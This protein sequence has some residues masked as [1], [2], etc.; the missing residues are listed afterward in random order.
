MALQPSVGPWPLFQFLNLYTVGRTPWTVDEPVARTTQTE[1][2][3]TQTPMPR[4]GFEPMV[5]VFVRAKTV[6]ATV[7]GRTLHASLVLSF[8]LSLYQRVSVLSL[9][10]SLNLHLRDVRCSKCS[11]IL[12]PRG[13]PATDPHTIATATWDRD[14][15][16]WLRDHLTWVM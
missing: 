10:L 12:I 3:R 15:S 13:L 9:L 4:V 5:Q 11:K 1:N 6:H 8:S 14:T 7:I 2:K 16:W